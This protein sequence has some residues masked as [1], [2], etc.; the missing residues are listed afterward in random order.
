MSECRHVSMGEWDEYVII[1]DKFRKELKGLSQLVKV[2]DNM[3]YSQIA[4]TEYAKKQTELYRIRFT[5]RLDSIG[6]T[7]HTERTVFSIEI[8]E[9]LVRAMSA[10]TRRLQSRLREAFK[11]DE[12]KYHTKEQ[13]ES[14]IEFFGY[15]DVIVTDIR[16]LL[17]KNYWT[18][19]KLEVR[20]P[21]RGPD[22]SYC[23]DGGCPYC[24]PWRFI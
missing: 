13:I 15:H 16:E 10:V 19:P 7:T 9:K 12:F 18:R 17:E 6:S 11:D 1:S 23:G 22:C 21:L 8:G 20:V 24:E 5:E 2:I 3:P 14:F 4:P